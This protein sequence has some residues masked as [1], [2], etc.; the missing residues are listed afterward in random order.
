MIG[1]ESM[2][3]KTPQLE[4]VNVHPV[5]S[6]TVILQ[7]RAL[8]AKRPISCSIPEKLKSYALRTT[9]TMSPFGPDTATL[10]SQ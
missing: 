9:G 8:T 5:M 3:P 4:M 2:D 7:S 6:S 10:M 1:V